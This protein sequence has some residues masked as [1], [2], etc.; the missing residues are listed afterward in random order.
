LSSP[1]S[2]DEE[3]LLLASLTDI[4]NPRLKAALLKLGRQVGQRR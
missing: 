4:G 2:A 1:L 3:R